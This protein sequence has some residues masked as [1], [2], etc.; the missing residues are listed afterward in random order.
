MARRG[1]GEYLYSLEVSTKKQPFS[2]T[3]PYQGLSD[4]FSVV[5][6]P[7]QKQTMIARK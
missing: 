6:K 1:K 2:V 3:S 7:D 4:L 5:E